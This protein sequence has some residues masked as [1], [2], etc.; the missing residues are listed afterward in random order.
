MPCEKNKKFAGVGE[1]RSR[2][3]YG[4]QQK[5]EFAM[6]ASF[7]DL[8]AELGYSKVAYGLEFPNSIARPDFCY[9]ANFQPDWRSRFSA[10][11]T[12]KL[13]AKSALGKR[14]PGLF[15]DDSPHWRKEDFVRE[16]QEHGLKFV[17][18]EAIP[19]LAGTTS[20]VGLAEG[21]EFPSTETQYNIRVLADYLAMS[22]TGCLVPKHMPQSL[23]EITQTET[24]CLQWVLDG[25]TAGEIADI[26]DL[27][28]YATR[29]M[30]RTLCEKF[31][32]RSILATAVLAYRM[33]LL[34][35]AN[36]CMDAD[37]LGTS[38]IRFG[39]QFNAFP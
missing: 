34:T 2:C 10:V 11:E 28:V 33:G 23:L 12:L 24:Q 38:V 39:S 35:A 26:L 6:F 5:S 21:D 8:A 1:W 14:T 3:L 25:K 18:L 17:W 15:E 36:L 13:G 30:Q 7:V 22:M 4:L 16:A 31:E 9:F 19:G 29:H 32:K 27:T 20:F 37:I